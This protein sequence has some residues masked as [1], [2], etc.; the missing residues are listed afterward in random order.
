MIQPQSSR[1]VYMNGEYVNEEDAKISIFD[2]SLM[3]G[4]MVFE[5]TR[6]YN[7]KPFKLHEHLNRLY[8]GL[9]LLEIDPGM[10]IEEMENITYK[11]IDANIE[12]FHD[13]VDFQIMH[14]ISR[15][16]LDKYSHAFP[17]GLHPTVT[18]NC[19]PLTWQLATYATLYEFGINAVITPQKSVPARL[20]DPKIKNR[21]RIYY[22]VANQQAHRMN[23]DA[24]A[25][26]TDD[27]GFITEGT[28]ANFFIV[29]DGSILTPKPYNIL[30]GITRQTV[31]DLAS[32]NGMICI[33]ENIDK[34]DVSTAD[35]AFYTSTSFAIMPVTTFNGLPVNNGENGPTVRTLQRLFG[36]LVGKDIIEQGIECRNI[37]D[38]E[39]IQDWQDIH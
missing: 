34:Y 3:F 12:T 27:D 19:W 37:V 35:E 30:R 20:I 39:E 29:R 31:I 1:V 32:N 8:A 18:I 11:T 23:P 5:I 33:E 14:N 15:G 13:G 25:L 17:N 10:P 6:T 7:G 21:S 9:K 2:S 24:W 26:L 16:P 4:D 38:M 22:Q 36:D 28:G